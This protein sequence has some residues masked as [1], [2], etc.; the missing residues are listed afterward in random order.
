MEIA[1]NSIEHSE[2]HV[3]YFAAQ[4]Y[5]VSNRDRRVAIAVGDYGIGI[6]ESFVGT[7]YES[8]NDLEA[9]LKAVKSGVSRYEEPS[10]G[11]GLPYSIGHPG[12]IRSGR[13][14]VR[15]GITAVSFI[16]GDARP[17]TRPWLP[18]TLITAMIDC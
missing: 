8:D 12:V 18:G 16:E 13:F 6:R 2:T 10:R 5:D 4:A 17:R 1:Q 7:Q 14:T 9:I 15:S 3:G 11:R